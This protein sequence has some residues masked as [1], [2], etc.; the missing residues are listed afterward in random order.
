MRINIDPV[1]S[2]ARDESSYL[3]RAVIGGSAVLFSQLLEKSN[4]A[5]NAMRLRRAEMVEQPS[6]FV[7][8]WA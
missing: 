5:L 4:R 8:R 2:S 7:L 1:P 6:G 3:G